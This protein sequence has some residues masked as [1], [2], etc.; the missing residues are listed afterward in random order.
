[1]KKLLTV[2]FDVTPLTRHQVEN[3]MS[4]IWVQGEGHN[5]PSS[6]ED[7]PDAIVLETS[8]R[9]VYDEADHSLIP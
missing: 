8:E 6:D 3:L 9:I 5:N 4:E 1:M 7:R 2:T